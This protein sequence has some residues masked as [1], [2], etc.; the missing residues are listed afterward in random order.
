MLLNLPN[1]QDLETILN[2]MRGQFEHIKSETINFNG[3]SCD[4]FKSLDKL[5]R[6]WNKSTIQ[7]EG[8]PVWGFAKIYA[9]KV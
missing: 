9:E 7:G 3:M 2:F 8:D 1:A 6:T 5:A 4:D